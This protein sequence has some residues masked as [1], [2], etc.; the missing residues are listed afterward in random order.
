MQVDTWG[1]FVFVNPDPEA[2]PLSDT[3]G[4]LPELVAKGGIDVDAL[5]FHHRS[6][7]EVNANVPGETV[8]M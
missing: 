5:R 8:M 6:E 3:L 7:F 4:E 1:P 2:G